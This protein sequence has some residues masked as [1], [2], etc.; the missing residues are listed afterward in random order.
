MLFRSLAEEGLSGVMVSVEGQM[1]LKY[2][3][4]EQLVRQSDLV[5]EVRHIIPGCDF[6]LLARF[7]EHYPGHK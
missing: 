6:H 2:V 5:T 7:L 4:F 1:Q 3:P